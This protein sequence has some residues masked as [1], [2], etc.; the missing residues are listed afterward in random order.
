MH[1]GGQRVN[2]AEKN[3]A[4]ARL[5]DRKL[6]KIGA[7]GENQGLAGPRARTVW[8]RRRARIQLIGACGVAGSATIH[9]LWA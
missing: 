7:G 1:R 9:L 3:V 4:G 6:R 8:Q 2:G 5:Q